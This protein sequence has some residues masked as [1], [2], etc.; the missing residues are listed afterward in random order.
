MK[1]VVD[2]YQALF[3]AGTASRK[4]NYLSLADH[5]YTLATNLYE[6]AW[7][8]SFHFASRHEGESFRASLLRYQ[9][10]VAERLSL[11]PGMTVLDVGCGIGGPM[12][13]L[14]RRFGASMVGININT[15]QLERAREQTRDVGSLCRFIHGDFMRIPE[16]DDSFD[17]AY[18]IDATCY[19]PDKAA[20][21]R[22]VCRVLRPG[23]CFACKEWCLT[24]RFD[25][26]N[27]DH[28][29][30]EESIMRGDGLPNIDT[31]EEV[32]TAVRDAGFD[33]LESQDLAFDS[34]PNT[35]WYRALEGRDLSVSSIAR[36]SVGRALTKLALR[37]GETLR[38][39]PEGM[40]EVSSLLNEGADALVEG[41]RT[42]IFTP[43]LFFLGRKPG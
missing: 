21:Y 39:L 3:D 23:A 24:E 34:H 41:G 12:G 29:R 9:D 28:R 22:E 1:S 35:P 19:A 26:R 8:P 32:L 10:F 37:T 14:A 6:F 11:K 16:E 43:M 27:A 5:Y 42:G 13:N 17:G 25:P 38:I 4:G 40:T 20:V 33:L 31:V 2:G 30:I 18:A 36:T 7:G 15:F